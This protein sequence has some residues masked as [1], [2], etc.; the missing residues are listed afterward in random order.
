[1]TESPITRVLLR[2][3]AGLTLAFIYVPLFVIAFYAFNENIN[4]T[5]PIESYTTKWFRV[6]WED[7]AVRDALLLSLK[8]AFGATAIAI[9]LGLLASLAVARYDFFGKETISFLVILP[10]ALPGMVAAHTELPVIGVPVPMGHLQGQ[11]ALLSIVQMPKGVPVATVAIDGAMNAALPAV[12][13][14]AIGDAGLATALAK[15]R[16]EMAPKPG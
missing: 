1:M 3:G 16:D 12:Q 8:A 2:V 7:E 6:A 14:L 13:M 9:V 5:W 15:H 10:I 4:L 11:D